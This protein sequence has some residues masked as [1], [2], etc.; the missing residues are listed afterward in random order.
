MTSMTVLMA[1]RNG[2]RFLRTA[3]E[4]VLNQTFRDFRFLIVDDESTDDTRRILREYQDPR[5]EL[6]ALEKNVGQTAALNIGLRRSE[7]PWIARMDADDFSHPTRLEEQWKVLEQDQ[8]LRC[9]GTAVWEFRDD[10]QQA[11]AVIQR[12]E[13]HREIQRA[14]L[15]GLGM[16][17]GSMVANREALLSIGGYDE[18]YRYASDRDLFIRLFSRYRGRNIPKPLLGIRRHAAQDSFSLGAADEYIEVFSHF[19]VSEGFSPEDRQKL[20]E[21]L[22]YSHL[23]RASC[24]RRQGD[25]AQT[26]TEWRRAGRTSQKVVARYLLARLGGWLVPARLRSRWS[27]KAAR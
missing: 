15:R 20:K 1:V 23:F 17:H 3:V 5:I 13:N 26:L 24:L 6:L 27:E 9:V 22:A 12:P 2:S 18:R 25:L 11:V 16:I 4:S 10:P 7:S 21:S 19:L 8:D 14:S